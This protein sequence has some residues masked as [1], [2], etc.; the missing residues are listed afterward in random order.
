[1][2]NAR[3]RQRLYQR[4]MAVWLV[5]LEACARKGIKVTHKYAARDT[6]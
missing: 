2:D 4:S 6:L 1:M 5:L 3:M